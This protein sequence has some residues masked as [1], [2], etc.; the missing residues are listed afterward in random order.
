M[1]PALTRH[2]IRTTPWATLAGGVTGTA[3]LVLLEV[4]TRRPPAVLGP[5]TLR[6]TTLPAVAALA[7]VP[8]ASFRPLVDA[9]PVPAWL[10]SAGQIVLAAPAL[11]LTCWVQLVIIG[12]HTPP[13]AVVHPVA[14]YPII[15]QI[16]GWCALTIAAAAIC[17]RSR[18]ADLG[19]A[20][21]AP[22]ALVL[23][24]IASYIPAARRLLA[25]PPAGPPTTAAA[26]YAIT[27]AAL[28]VTAVV[29]RDRWHRYTRAI[30]P[31]TGRATKPL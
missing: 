11:A 9:T 27:A 29:L 30:R 23:L 5:D 14:W 6:L 10:T 26:W 7:F 4:V 3:L 28:A 20:V 15:A 24:A 21:A 18:Y 2:V 13:G 25:T 16:T 8:R 12:H 19:G 17:D 22:T 1:L 31:G